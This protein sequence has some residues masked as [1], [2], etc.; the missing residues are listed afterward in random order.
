MDLEAGVIEYEPL[1]DP[2]GGELDDSPSS[3]FTW[4]DLSVRLLF[5]LLIF[6]SM[7]LSQLGLSGSNYSKAQMSIM[8]STA[9]LGLLGV[10]HLSVF[11]LSTS[12]SIRNIFFVSLFQVVL[13]N[14]YDESLFGPKLQGDLLFSLCANLFYLLLVPNLSTA[15]LVTALS[16]ATLLAFA[17]IALLGRA[18]VLPPPPVP[19][20]PT[21]Q[22]ARA[23]NQKYLSRLKG[24]FFGE[25]GMVPSEVKSHNAW[26]PLNLST[27]HPR[28]KSE[29]GWG[30]PQHLNTS[31][32]QPLN[33]SHLTVAIDKSSE[34][35]SICFAS[36][37]PGAYV[38]TLPGCGHEFHYNC[39][40]AWLKKN[41]TCPCCRFDL[42]AY[43]Q[44]NEP[45]A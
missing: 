34:M 15:L 22:P 13:I 24:R 25:K 11:F 3:P 12:K 19:R 18:G 14:S 33:P 20:P 5:F 4:I 21:A 2:E 27:S 29:N 30:T 17:A 31:T 40:R 1:H 16:S 6:G 41:P 23:F 10:Q 26:Q 45:L 37:E 8:A 43:F 38:L 28:C 32:P 35:C 39:V 9:L 36:L 44:L 7:G 42:L